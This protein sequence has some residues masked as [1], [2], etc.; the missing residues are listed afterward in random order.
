MRAFLCWFPEEEATSTGWNRLCEA[1]QLIVQT[2]LD[3][4]GLYE[5]AQLPSGHY[6]S[7]PNLDTLPERG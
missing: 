4:G 1:E 3:Q 7:L 6:Y 2:R 5:P